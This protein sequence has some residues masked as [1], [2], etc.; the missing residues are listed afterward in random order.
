MAFTAPAANGIITQTDRDSN[1]SGLSVNGGVTITTD[2]GVTYYDFGSNRLL[3]EGSIF[4]NPE[5]EVAIFHHISTSQETSTSVLSINNSVIA[6]GS[7][8]SWAKN[9]AGLLV[10]TKAAH[11][12]QV[13][14]AVKVRLNGSTTSDGRSINNRLFRISAAT[15]DTMTLESSAMFSLPTTVGQYQRRPC[16]NYGKVVTNRGRTRY[17]AGTGLIFSGNSVTN[18]DPEEYSL[19]VGYDG[20]F[21]GRGGV[22]STYRPFNLGGFYDIAGTDFVSTRT[23]GDR[24]EI[25]S[26][27]VGIYEGGALVNMAGV[28]I[29]STLIFKAGLKQASITEVLG[30][31][32]E[33]SIKDFDVT[34]NANDYDIGHDGTSSHHHRDYEIVNSANGS[35]VINMWR[36]TR[37]ALGQRGCLVTKKEVAFALKDATGSAVS[38]AKMYCQDNPS[39]YAKNATLTGGTTEGVYTTTPT[40]LNGTLNGDGT[41][42]YSY[43]DPFVYTGTTNSSGEIGTI[44]VTT[45]S[46]ILEYNSNDSSALAAN[47][48]P[49]N[50]PSFNVYW[51]ETDNA[52]PAYSDYDT[53]RFGGFYRVDRRSNDNSNADEFTFKFASYEH[54]L[55]QTTQALKGLGE[56]EV[57]WVMFDDTAISADRATADGYS[58]INTP[59]AF[60]NRAKAYLVDNY[61]GETATIV[62]REGT[63]INA[64]AY[65]V[66]IDASAASVFAFDGSTITIKATQFVGN[67]TG[68]GTFTLLNGAEVL[69]TFGGSTVYPWEVSNVEAG[70]TLQ[71][72]NVTQNAEIE[73]LVINGT[74]GTKVNASGSYDS[75]EAVPSDTI[76]LRI[77]CQAGVN[78]LLP[79]ETYGVATATGISLRADQQPDTVYNA[80]NIDGSSI[81]GITLTPDY[82]N[83]QIDL[84]DQVAPYEISAQAIYNY[85]SYLITTPQGIAN[86][87]GAI[88]PIDRLNYRI[89][90]SVVPLKLQNTGSTDVI[91]NGGRLYRD[92]NVSIID[93][94][95]GSGTGSL[96]QDTGMLIQYLQ[97]QVESA[98]TT[99][100][101]ATTADLT[102]TETALKKKITQAALL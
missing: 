50:I 28:N 51:R 8:Q 2:A 35:N 76:R 39:P 63:T 102:A 19:N 72:F 38:G 71:L 97:P 75:S 66:T 33:V 45:S 18:W 60:Y 82:S 26:M 73:N 69:G 9:A 36:D 88:T 67:I 85:Y 96:S 83:I 100:G 99:Y 30:E 43:A 57:S 3:V 10:M 92:D 56:L 52:L 79:F 32:Y 55:A 7:P 53:D 12:L 23:V 40:L 24:V 91:I 1:L 6:W 58:E 59:Q 16:Y 34:Q 42:T 14:D 62:S 98:L 68:S 89:N 5:K 94:G 4:H 49:Y 70:S 25:R 27:G 20:F 15:T 44:K 84:D 93:S 78:A 11:G 87:Y 95:T 13:G 48:G 54:S 90:A 64:G 37:G 47:G 61:A 81:S 74:A 17:A 77:T 86:F 41:I 21:W 22:I 29:G 46:H 101:S 65:N 80:N 31:W